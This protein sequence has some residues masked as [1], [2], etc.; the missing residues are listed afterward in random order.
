MKV[1][2]ANKD[3]MDIISRETFIS[4]ILNFGP[5]VAEREI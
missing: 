4:E 3:G 5:K 1:L 2:M